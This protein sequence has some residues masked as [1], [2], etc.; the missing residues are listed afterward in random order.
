MGTTMKAKYEKVEQRSHDNVICFQ[1]VS[2]LGRRE[3]YKQ[4][5][6]NTILGGQRRFR[7]KTIK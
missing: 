1:I 3:N 2:N 4:K 5:V 7:G 6:R